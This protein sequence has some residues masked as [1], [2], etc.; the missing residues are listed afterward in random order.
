L[1]PVFTVSQVMANVG[2]KGFA[3]CVIGGWGDIVGA[4]V[5]GIV[6][7]LVEVFSASYISSVYKDAIVFAV[8]IGFLLFRPQGLLGRAVEESL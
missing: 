1:A 5:G 3:A 8:L 7:G 2:L 6:V 4:V